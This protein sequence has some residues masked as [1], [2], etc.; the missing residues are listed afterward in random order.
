MF[1]VCVTSKLGP[2]R[3]RVGGSRW[4]SGP[5]TPLKPR[6]PKSHPSQRKRGSQQRSLLAVC[7]HPWLVLS[8]AGLGLGVKEDA[9]LLSQVHSRGSVPPP[10]CCGDRPAILRPRLAPGLSPVPRA[11][12]QGPALEAPGAIGVGGWRVRMRG[13][14]SAVLSAGSRTGSETGHTPREGNPPE[15]L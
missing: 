13:S 2:A 12:L 3:G 8:A 1:L 11:S 15:D 6:A 7:V 4:H 14:R 10:A 9:R 5:L